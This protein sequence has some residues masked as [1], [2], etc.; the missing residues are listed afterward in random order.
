MAKYI[1]RIKEI[2]QRLADVGAPVQELDIVMTLLGGLPE[3]YEG[4]ITALGVSN[5]GLTLE[6]I[7]AHL[8]NEEIRR[9]GTSKVSQ[10]ESVLIVSKQKKDSKIQKNFTQIP[11]QKKYPCKYCHELGHWI[12]DCPKKIADNQKKREPQ[13]NQV[14]IEDHLLIVIEEEPAQEI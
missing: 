7:C 13:V 14:S 2:A 8:Q 5:T 6:V 1:G 4:L 9:D 11:P 12:K 3:S 10:E